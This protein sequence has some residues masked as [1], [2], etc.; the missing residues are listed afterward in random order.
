M[1]STRLK[2]TTLPPQPVVEVHE[3]E[4]RPAWSGQAIGKTVAPGVVTDQWQGT[5]RRKLKEKH[6]KPRAVKHT[7]GP[8]R[9][10]KRGSEGTTGTE[11]RLTVVHTTAPVRAPAHAIDSSVIPNVTTGIFGEDGGV[12]LHTP[13]REETTGLK[14]RVEAASISHNTDGHKPVTMEANGQDAPVD[15]QLDQDEFDRFVSGTGSVASAFTSPSRKTDT[16]SPASLTPKLAAAEAPGTTVDVGAPPSAH[17]EGKGIAD[18]T[19]QDAGKRPRRRGT[20]SNRTPKQA[21]SRVSPPKLDVLAGNRFAPLSQMTE[22]NRPPPLGERDTPPRSNRRVVVGRK[23]HASSPGPHVQRT[24]VTLGDFLPTGGMASKRR[25][26]RNQ[27]LTLEFGWDEGPVSAW[28]PLWSDRDRLSEAPTALFITVHLL[29]SRKRR[30]RLFAGLRGTVSSHFPTY[31]LQPYRT[32]SRSQQPHRPVS[33]PA[34]R[35]NAPVSKRAQMHA[36]S[37]L[38]T[39]PAPHTPRVSPHPAPRDPRE[40]VGPQFTPREASAQRP[41][42]ARMQQ[43]A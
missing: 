2:L 9:I 7:A 18:A 17:A 6:D 1:D 16:A 19:A 15:D 21:E 30:R 12:N 31:A 5:V 25:D 32:W 22:E 13:R 37:P 42:Q 4:E 14:E 41:T 35:L 24:A 11:E 33:T 34:R 3:L 27:R 36:S 40:I 23:P 39:R 26:S 20:R 8:I 10:L 28:V 29:T 38:L 43:H